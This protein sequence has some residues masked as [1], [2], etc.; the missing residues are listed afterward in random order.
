MRFGEVLGMRALAKAWIVF[1]GTAI[2]SHLIR[3][4]ATIELPLSI[5][6]TSCSVLSAMTAFSPAV[7]LAFRRIL[8]VRFLDCWFLAWIICAGPE[9]MGF[10]RY[11]LIRG[12]YIPWH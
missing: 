7:A 9:F 3:Y 12:N 8:H 10:L 2:L 6:A 4:Q 1:F 5:Y 11:T